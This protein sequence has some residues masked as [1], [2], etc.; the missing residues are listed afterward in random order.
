M[1]YS[2]AH[3]YP[4]SLF[5]ICTIAKAISHPARAKILFDLQS[6]KMRA[7]ELAIDH[8]IST[9]SV[10]RHCQ[11]LLNTELISAEVIGKNT[12]YSYNSTLIPGL[13]KNAISEIADAQSYPF[14]PPTPKNLSH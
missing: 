11:V 12:F 14:I 13:V 7:T 2:K 4:D 1:G 8:P 3:K 6:G 9:Q 5:G 10:S